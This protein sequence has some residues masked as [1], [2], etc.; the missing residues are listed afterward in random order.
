MTMH[1]QNHFKRIVLNLY[2]RVNTATALN[3][4][5]THY[6]RNGVFVRLIDSQKSVAE[7]AGFL[8]CVAVL[9]DEYFPVFGES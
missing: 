7:T 4:Q 1:G 3:M 9:L 8:R 2:R 6:K 5:P